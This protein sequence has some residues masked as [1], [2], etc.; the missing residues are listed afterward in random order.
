MSKAIKDAGIAPPVNKR[1]WQWL[2]DNGSHTGL[3]IATAL[4]IPS[5]ASSSMLSQMLVR[6]MVA[7][8]K[9]RSE[10]LKRD[11][12]YY[13][14]IGRSFVVLPVPKKIDPKPPE[15]ENQVVVLEKIEPKKP[16]V[17]EILETLSV[18]DAF[19]LYERLDHMF[20]KKS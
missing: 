18:V 4:N 16:R 8:V 5:S 15:P 13:S 6:K 10:H 3:E 12:T 7:G 2:K 20:N 11:V 17:D 1:I 9:K 19:A 14:A